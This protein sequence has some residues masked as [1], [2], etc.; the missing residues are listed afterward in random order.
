MGMEKEDECGSCAQMAKQYGS[1]GPLQLLIARKQLHTHTHTR[2]T[3]IG[4][5]PWR[6]PYGAKDAEKKGESVMY[7]RTFLLDE[8]L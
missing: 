3:L 8:A 6:G 5:S 2:G 4:E 7:I 1:P